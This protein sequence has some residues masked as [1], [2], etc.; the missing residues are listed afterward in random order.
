[1][2][3]LGF[4]ALT[5]LD[6]KYTLLVINLHLYIFFVPAAIYLVLNSKEPDT[7]YLGVGIILIAIMIGIFSL[8]T[9]FRKK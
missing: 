5:G 9:I 6:D 4:L 7:F 2:G 8:I 1:M 3:L